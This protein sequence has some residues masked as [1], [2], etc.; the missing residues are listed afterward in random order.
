MYTCKK[1]CMFVIASLV[2]VSCTNQLIE[3]NVV[4]DSAEQTPTSEVTALIE[5]PFIT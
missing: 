4:G 1:K 5:N 2:L 3:S